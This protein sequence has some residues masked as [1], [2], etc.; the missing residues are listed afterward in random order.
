MILKFTFKICIAKHNEASLPTPSASKWDRQ[1]SSADW[2]CV[3]LDNFDID[4]KQC[5]TIFVEGP[6]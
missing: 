5:C 1:C 4:V 3:K 2:K 6:Y